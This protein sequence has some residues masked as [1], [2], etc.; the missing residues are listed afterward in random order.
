[1]IKYHD[2]SNVGKKSFIKLTVLHHSPLSKKSGQ[3]L[4]GQERGGRNGSRDH[5]EFCFLFPHGF[6][7]PVTAPPTVPGTPPL[8]PLLILLS[9]GYLKH[10]RRAVVWFVKGPL[11]FALF[12]FHIYSDIPLPAIFFKEMCM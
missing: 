10:A 1:M 11:L 8:Q 9:H 2:Q 5:G 6:L 3:P 7:S 4:T 12:N